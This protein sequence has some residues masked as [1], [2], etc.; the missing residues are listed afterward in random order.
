MLGDLL[1]QLLTRERF[2]FKGVE[3]AQDVFSICAQV[4]GGPAAVLLDTIES[5][6]QAR[7][8]LRSAPECLTGTAPA[9]L[10]LTG[11]MT[12][13]DVLND[14]MVDGIVSVPVC[15]DRLIQVV[16]HHA[17]APKQVRG[18]SVTPLSGGPTVRPS[19]QVG[20]RPRKIAHAG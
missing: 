2:L 4:E 19:E 12:A 16:G 3:T 7:R 9:F 18:A 6:D 5:T 13:A 15:A 10:L 17:R 14:P 8:L 20:A 1:N 11:S